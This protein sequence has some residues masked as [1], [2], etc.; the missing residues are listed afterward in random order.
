MYLGLDFGTTSTVIS[1]A[2]ADGDARV[3]SVA[4]FS[5]TK[6]FSDDIDHVVPSAI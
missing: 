4:P 5:F 6:K 1:V 2:S 3:V